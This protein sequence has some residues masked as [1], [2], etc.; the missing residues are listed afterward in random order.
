MIIGISGKKQHGKDTVCKIIQLL[1]Y[2]KKE[3][4]TINEWVDSTGVFVTETVQFQSGWERK[5]FAD[6]LK[7]MV[8]MLIGCTREQLEDNTFK[9][10]PLS[11]WNIWMPFSPRLNCFFGNLF[12]TKEEC[13][14]EIVYRHTIGIEDNIIPRIRVMTPRL[15]MQLLGTD[16]GRKIIHP[17]IWVN[18]LMSEYHPM[19]KYK[20][21]GSKKDT[22]VYPNWIVTDVRFPNEAKAIEDK[23]GIV[24][25]VN[26]MFVQ[27][28]DNHESETALD[29]HN[30]K[31]TICNDGSI[32]A[33]I[34]MV[35]AT[36]RYTKII[37]N[38]PR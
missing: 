19:Y 34:E 30:F 16:C 3:N 4:T 5:L 11:G 14:Q 9:E 13:L 28:E 7:D 18:A 33:L 23:G 24:I 25:R 6:K 29:T 15:L 12:Y 22:I 2:C 20:E 8:C 31:Y 36:L 32:D 17:N 27:S 10:T 1:M 21:I 35:R 26:R 38:D 37:A